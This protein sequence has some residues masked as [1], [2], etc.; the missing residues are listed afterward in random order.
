MKLNIKFVIGF[1]LLFVLCISMFEVF[2]NYHSLF[3]VD[4]ES[5]S[6]ASSYKGNKY[7]DDLF[8]KNITNN[9]DE[10]VSIVVNNTK[11]S[12]NVQSSES[13]SLSG[14]NEASLGDEEGVLATTN[15][16]KV[17]PGDLMDVSVQINSSICNVEEVYAKM[18]YEGGY[19]NLSLNYSYKRDGIEFWNVTWEVHDT[20]TAVYKSDIDVICSNGKNL[21][22]NVYWYDPV[23]YRVNVG[24]TKN[25]DV[26]DTCTKVTNGWSHDLFI[27]TQTQ[28][29]WDNFKN[30][31]PSGVTFTSCCIDV[32]TYPTSSMPV[33]SDNFCQL[34]GEDLVLM[35][36]YTDYYMHDYVLLAEPDPGI[37]GVSWFE[38]E[39]SGFTLGCSEG[40][41]WP[42][43]YE[44]TEYMTDEHNEAR[45]LYSYWESSQYGKA[46]EDYPYPQYQ[47]FRFWTMT[48]EKSTD[49]FGDSYDYLYDSE[50]NDGVE[51]AIVYGITAFGPYYG[52]VVNKNRTHIGN[53]IVVWCVKGYSIEDISCPEEADR[54]CDG[55]FNYQDCYDYQLQRCEDRLVDWANSC[56]DAVNY[57]QS[58]C[59]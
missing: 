50:F 29:E 58:C 44:S 19:D 25:I 27:P 39:S 35:A 40:F 56:P 18:P 24:E 13:L 49:F 33:R 55:S 3:D 6:S 20:I 1:V 54:I 47:Y 15:P 26:F 45:H 34:P 10:N 22:A 42:Y 8:S 17:R 37:M 48:E 30:N 59:N 36:R 9:Y 52:H 43:F 53:P 11:D 31:A 7:T 51:D 5:S 28:T 57:C 21:N 41:R 2:L 14:Y 12:S 46:R 4:V 16:E 32:E 23:Y 38:G